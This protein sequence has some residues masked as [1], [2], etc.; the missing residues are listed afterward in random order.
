MGNDL[1]WATH[2]GLK[3]FPAREIASN[4][5]SSRNSDF[6]A[7]GVDMASALSHSRQASPKQLKALRLGRLIKIARKVCG[8][9]IL[10]R[11]VA[12]LTH[13]STPGSGFH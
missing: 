11:L 4:N 8:R 12:P 5:G 2:R 10:E 9:V 3:L 1:R 6:C 13:L 7:T